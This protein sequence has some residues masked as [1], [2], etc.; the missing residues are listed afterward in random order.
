MLTDLLSEA[1]QHFINDTAGLGKAASGIAQNSYYARSKHMERPTLLS[2][3]QVHH[4]M[5]KLGPPD[6]PQAPKEGPTYNSGN[7]DRLYSL[8]EEEGASY[9]LLLQ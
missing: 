6:N 5:K 3:Q 1:D 2:L 4:I 8:L 9:I 7:I